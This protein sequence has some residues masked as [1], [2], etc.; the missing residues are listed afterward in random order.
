[1]WYDSWFISQMLNLFSEVASCD[2]TKLT[3]VQCCSLAIG[4]DE[5]EDGTQNRQ[6]STEISALTS[7]LAED[8]I[9]ILA[10]TYKA[11]GGPRAI[12]GEC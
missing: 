3:I 8:N 4:A 6:Y 10:R 7:A 9:S 2:L 11:N 1:M 5:L 12:A